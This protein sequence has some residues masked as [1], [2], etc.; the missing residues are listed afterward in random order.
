MSTARPHGRERSHPSVL[1]SLVYLLLN[2]PIG[3]AAFVVLLP[4]TVAGLGTAIV[5]IGLP[6][7]AATVLL[8]RGAAN[9]ER[10]RAYALLGTYIPPA[11]RP[12]PEG[13]AR[14]RWRTR[15]TDSAT[16]REYGYLFLLFPL[17]VVELVL[18]VASWGISLALLT[19]PVYYRFLP[20]GVWR[21]PSTEPSLSWVTV[22]SVGSALPWSAL[23]LL[24][25][26]CT[27]LLTRGLGTAHG[28]LAGTMLGPTS[29]RMREFDEAGTALSPARS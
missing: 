11:T 24:L 15:L 8:T 10:A 22:D 13:N 6:V 1:G 14:Q 28:R 23:G 7:L 27:A 18:M 2:F 3:V 19:L 20:G 5:W 9:V 25:L 16:W 12:L 26:V 17:G 29:T 4:L 21:F